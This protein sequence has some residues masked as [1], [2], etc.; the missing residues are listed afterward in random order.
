MKV[1]ILCGGQ[2]TRLREETEFRPKP[3]IE[4]GGRPILWH[5]MRHYSDHGFN[6]FV[7]CLG[8]KGDAIREYFLEYVAMNTDVRISLAEQ[9][10][11][12]LDRLEL[13]RD[14]TVTL[15]ETGA[16]TG[17]G[18]R[19]KRAMRHLDGDAFFWT[20]GDGVSNVDINGLLEFHRSKGR[21]ATA[22][23]VRPPSRFGELE[24]R[25]GLATAFLEKPQLKSGRVSGGFFVMEPAA[26]SFIEGDEMFERGPMERLVAAEQLAIY[27]HDG[28]WAS[29]DTYR[30]MVQLNEEWASGEAGWRRRL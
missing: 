8:Y 23:G 4:I 6:D 5:I 24:I 25:A 29:M 7:L 28:Y 11:R 21:L 26:L 2:G 9:T 12:Y 10:V 20:Y 30:D 17:T 15:C 14:W 19:L 13:E 27:E 1:V 16:T 3:M 18:G 22:T